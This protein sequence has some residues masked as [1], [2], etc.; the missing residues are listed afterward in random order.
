MNLK[1]VQNTQ[2][3]WHILILRAFNEKQWHDKPINIKNFNSELCHKDQ[4]S[5]DDVLIIHLF[6][7][8]T[9][10][11]NYKKIRTPSPG[12][13]NKQERMTFFVRVRRFPS[14]E[15]T[16]SLN[17]FPSSS[18]ITVPYRH[19]IKLKSETKHN[20]PKTCFMSVLVRLYVD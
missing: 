18:I 4:C 19:K 12:Q 17:R 9:Q 8:I 13:F 20:V 6:L 2:K 16:N 11:L 14:K 10:S 5:D 3:R 1:S 7:L 15:F